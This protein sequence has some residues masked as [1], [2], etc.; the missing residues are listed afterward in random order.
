[1]TYL[2]VYKDKLTSML[3]EFNNFKM[4]DK[5]KEM[6]GQMSKQFFEIN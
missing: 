4:N 1:M 3:N 5:E 6:F 2:D